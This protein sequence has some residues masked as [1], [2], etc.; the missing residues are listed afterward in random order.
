[1]P[2]NSD[3]IF[4]PGVDFDSSMKNQMNRN[5]DDSINILQTQWQQADLDQRFVLG[6]QDLW[7]QL[8]PNSGTYRRK[9]FNFNLINSMIQMVSGYQRRN[10]KT[11]ICIPLQTQMQKTADQFTK[12]LYHVHNQSGAYQIY[13]DAF[14]QGALSQGI[15][16]ISIY[17]D[18]SYD[19]SGEIKLR[20]IDFKS[21]LIDPFFRKH[22]LSDCR[23][24][25]TR[26]F[27]DKEEAALLYPKFGD[28]IRNLPCGSYKDDKFYY[29]PEVYQIQFPNL[30][31]FDEY[32]YLS[33]REAEF[34]VDKVTNEVQEFKGD[35]ED[36][37]HAK[38]MFGDRFKL[39]KKPRQ[40]VR[41]A[42]LINDKVLVDEENPY[43]MDRYPFVPFLGYFTPDTSYYSYKFKGLTRDMRDAQYLFNRRKVADLDI[44]ESQQQGMKIKKGAL[45]TPEDGLNQ[46]SGR[47]LV[48]SEKHQMSDIEPMPIIPP[49]PTMIQMEEQLKDVMR[50][51][52]GV[53][54]EL[55]G[56]AVDDK[57]GILSMLRQGA[58][59]TTLQRLFDQFDESQRLCGD[60]IIEMIQKNWTFNKVRQ[61]IGEEPT[62]EF[63]DKAFFKYGAKI[64]QGVLTESQH[65]LEFQQLLHLYELT[66]SSNPVLLQ[67]AIE[68]ST[69]QEK[70]ELLKKMAEYQ[71]AQDEQQKQTQQIQQ[72]QLQVDMET[73]LA[74]AQSQKGLAAER[75]AKIQTDRAVAEDKLSRA[76][77][78]DTASL[79]NLVKTIK[80]LQSIDTSNIMSKIETLHRINDL[81]FD[82]KREMREED[83]VAGKI[84]TI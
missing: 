23:F 75:V 8:F 55:L 47:I 79:L 6:D 5:Y 49:A 17:N 38:Y 24:V 73:K 3:P 68:V 39:I 72:Q 84:S 35:E 34:L 41:R 14:E 44:L 81:E 22:D 65:Q 40:T 46:G 71:Q 82:K 31:A 63:D 77:Q 27:F 51:I 48:V 12:C 57:A 76:E 69:V 53:N 25:W 64:V 11:S 56:S 16:L 42:V 80:E 37:R 9:V 45:V 18:L 29:M 21:I 66:G 13:S 28:E 15:G 50:Q 59:L 1:M 83:A 19:P 20:Y 32:W 74:Y 7:G 10:R 70:D 60:I 30:V 54:E 2:R 78:E 4:F 36:L 26:Q 43:G 58:G 61:V 62:P 67:R 52:S 33:S